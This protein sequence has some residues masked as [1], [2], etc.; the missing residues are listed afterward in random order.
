M[1]DVNFH[2]VA[3]HSGSFQTSTQLLKVCPLAQFAQTGPNQD[4][5]PLMTSRKLFLFIEADFKSCWTWNPFSNQCPQEI[6][7]LHL[8]QSG[9]NWSRLTLALITDLNWTLKLFLRS[10]SHLFT[11]RNFANSFHISSLPS[12]AQEVLQREHS[13]FLS[14]Q[15]SLWTSTSALDSQ[16]EAKSNISLWYRGWDTTHLLSGWTLSL[17]GLKLWGSEI[18]K[19]WKNKPSQKV[20]LM[21]SDLLMTSQH[22]GQHER[23][24]CP[25]SWCHFFDPT[26]ICILH[27]KLSSSNRQ[28]EQVPSQQVPGQVHVLN[29]VFKVPNNSYLF[30]SVIHCTF[31]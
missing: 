12:L 2:S 28:D 16:Q 25:K 23:Q 21:K 5:M 31:S 8:T 9:P 20:R 3:H 18:S 14:P 19:I 4:F 7:P 13:C 15:V 24:L 17:L 26:D 29:L 11:S 6:L 30:M 27:R 10:L 1:W 22:T